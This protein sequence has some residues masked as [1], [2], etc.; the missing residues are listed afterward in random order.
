MYVCIYVYIY[1]H[2]YIY[3]YIDVYVCL[4]NGVNPCKCQP[5]REMAPTPLAYRFP[6]DIYYI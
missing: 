5:F 3:I 1:I 2:I 4:E 6:A